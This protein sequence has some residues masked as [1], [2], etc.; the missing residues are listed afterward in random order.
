[1]RYRI[2]GTNTLPS[3]EQGDRRYDEDCA[4]HAREVLRLWVQEKGGQAK[5]AEF[6]GVDQGTISRNLDV[7]KQPTL[8]VL[9]LLAKRSGKSLEQIFGLGQPPPS[10]SPLRLSDSQLQRVADKVAEQVKRSLTPKPMPA[11]RPPPKTRPPKK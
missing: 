10:S 9:I 11:V 2:T 1:M 6:L 4:D 5:A 8:K 3:M 7:T